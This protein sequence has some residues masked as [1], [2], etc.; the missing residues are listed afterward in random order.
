MGSGSLA[1]GAGGLEVAVAMAGHPFVTAAPEIVGV[2]LDGALSDWV[3]AKD[4]ILEL[5]RRFGVRGGVGTI[6]EFFGDG[7]ATLSATERATICNM[8]VETGATTGVFP[9]DGR[10]REWLEAQGRGG[11]WVELGAGRGCRVRPGRG[12]RPRRAR[13]A[14]RAAELPRERRPGARGRGHAHG[15]GLRRLVR[16][17]LVRGSRGGRRRAARADAAGGRRS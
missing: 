7:V 8:V 9:S 11:D 1:I 2:R 15:P 5:L 16:E 12:D 17:L 10:V 3:E 6:F 4:V 13:A 14:D